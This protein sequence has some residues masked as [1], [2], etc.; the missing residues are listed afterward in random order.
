MASESFLRPAAVKPPRRL[1]EAVDFGAVL[2]PLVS[3][4][5]AAQRARAAAASLARVAGDMGRRLPRPRPIPRLTP[6]GAEKD[7][8]EDEEEEA[9]PP[10]KELRRASSACICSRSE[11]ASFSL[12]SDRS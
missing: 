4:R 8:A 12:S 2:P 11:T 5:A 9:P 7:G 3:P 1:L 6:G 10:N